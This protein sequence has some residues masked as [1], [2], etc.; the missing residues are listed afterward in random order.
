MWGN[1]MNK[2]WLVFKYEYAHH[3]MKKRF[4]IALLSMPLFIGVLIAA[5]LASAMASTN[6]SPIGYVN[7]LELLQDFQ[8]AKPEKGFMSTDVEYLPFNTAVEADKA[9]QKGE[10]QAYYILDESYSKDGS[11]RLVYLK[12]PAQTIQNKFENQI[13]QTLIKTQPAA[14]VNRLT[15]GYHL[16]LISVD[17]TRKMG[18]ND[19]INIVVI[20]IAGFFFIMTLITSSGY[21]MSALVEEKENRTMEILVTSISPDQLMMGK[22]L[23]NLSV[24][25][26][27]LA[28]WMLALFLGYLLGRDQFVWLQSLNISIGTILTIAA[29]VVPG[30]VLVAALMAMLGSTVTESREAQQLTGLITLPVVCPYWITT[31]IIMNPNGSLAVGMSFFP[32]TAPL[33]MIFRVSISYVPAW[34]VILSSGILTICAL[35]AIWLAARAFRL[36]MVRYGKKVSLKELLSRQVVNHA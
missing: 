7:D 12:L 11:A 3:V 27:Q 13:H 34:Q 36:G 32:L 16:T 17:G 1:R 26:T 2:I 8:P 20:N 10:I 30:F 9:L 21:L 31:P 4:L 15:E 24:G 5:S 22:V 25:L 6:R 33:T 23:G 35:G 14:I 18:E 28:V 29:V 19:W